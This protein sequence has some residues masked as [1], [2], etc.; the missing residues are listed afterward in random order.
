MIGRFDQIWFMDF[1]FSAPDGEHPAIACLVA[2]ELRSGKH[3]RLWQDEIY[4][5]E[6]PPYDVGRNNLFCAY[7]ASAEMNC[8]LALG[9]PLPHNLLDLFTEF[10]VMTNGVSVPCGNGLLGALAYFGLD[11]IEATEKEEMRSLAM[12]G[13]PW[14]PDEKTRLLDYCQSDV[15]ALG[16]LFLSMEPRIDW[17]RALLRGRYM[18]AA[19]RM[20]HTGVPIDVDRLQMLRANWSLIQDHLIQRI[21]KDFGFYD[22]RR[23]KH[24]RFERW[25]NAHNIPW[26]RLKSGQLALND[27]K[28]KEMC[29]IHPILNPVRELR[30]SLSQLRLESLAIGADRRNR[31][32]LSAFKATT[33]RNA[34]ST[35]KFIFGPAV[36][37]RNLIRP[38]PAHGLAY[39]DWSSQEYAIAAY[40]SGD[41]N[42][43][44]AYKSGDVYLSLA[45]G[46]GAAPPDATKESHQAVRELYKVVQLATQ[47][48]QGAKSLAETIGKSTAEARALLYNQEQLYRTFWDWSEAALSYALA[49]KKLCSV[50]GW[51]IQ[52]PKSSHSNVRSLRNFP[53]Q[54]NGSEMLRL[55]CCLATERGIRVC[56]PIHDAILIES[57]IETLESDVEKARQAMNEAS[58]AVL[59]GH[60]VRTDAKLVYWPDHYT[61][62]RGETMWNLISEVLNL[63][64]APMAA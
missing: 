57:P 60:V 36:W 63:A 5:L 39:I 3:L 28:F 38:E 26:P 54:A 16:K 59:G 44:A 21:D 45:K 2:H 19:A 15:D 61:D 27:D 23:F 30:Y 4:R 64:D 49:F 42:M 11:A 48:G 56:A 25:L 62:P 41:S 6:S 40:L 14:T 22:G 17:P 12:R 20:E 24:D 43:I 31:T 46:V 50:F 37:L 35:S 53:M 55:A 8:H 34:P 51:Q 47:Y 9:W 33:G 10:R 29:K 1:E 13:P 7:Y 18:K 52:L 32:I 58:A